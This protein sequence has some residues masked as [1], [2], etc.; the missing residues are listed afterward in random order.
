MNRSLEASDP[1][2]V[3]K[4]FR[5][6][7]TS[8]CTSC[9]APTKKGWKLIIEIH[10]KTRFLSF[11]F[12]HTLIPSYPQTHTYA[13]VLSMLGVRD[14][15][16]RVHQ[17]FDEAVDNNPSLP[18][19]IKLRQLFILLECSF[20]HV[21]WPTPP[22]ASGYIGLRMFICACISFCVCVWGDGFE[23]SSTE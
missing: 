18:A 3:L 6:I 1:Y 9:A 12:V 16:V 11:D 4:G 17:Q 14:G 7:Q 2:E 23:I 5:D 21:W 15:T 8:P 22:S 10:L 13:L 19:G 20:M